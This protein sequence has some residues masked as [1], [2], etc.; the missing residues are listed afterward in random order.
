MM[1]SEVIASSWVYS[2]AQARSNRGRDNHVYPGFGGAAW[3]GHTDKTTLLAALQGVK[4]K[5]SSRH[6]VTPSAFGYRCD[7]ELRLLLRI[8]NEAPLLGRLRRSKK[9]S[10]LAHVRHKV[11]GASF[12]DLE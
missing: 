12:Y 9:L 8:T 6:M 2:T 11:F 1:P 5:A 10:G 3:P 4:M 7:D